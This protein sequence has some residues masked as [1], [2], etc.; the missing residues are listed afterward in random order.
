MYAKM[1]TQEATTVTSIPDVDI[2]MRIND[3]VVTQIKKAPEEDIEGAIETMR[4]LTNC[5]TD[6]IT[7]GHCKAALKAL[8]LQL[9]MEP[10][11]K[12]GNPVWGHCPTCGTAV[13]QWM[14][15]VG[16]KKCLQKLKWS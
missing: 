8:K 7:E 16:C 9:P 12:Q 5:A 3:V 4:L 11:D 13:Y 1:I 2:V 15:S 6:E 14:N 10:Q